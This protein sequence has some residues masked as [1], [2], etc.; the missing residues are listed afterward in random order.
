M[1]LSRKKQDEL[2]NLIEQEKEYVKYN[3]LSLFLNEED[4]VTY[5][6]TT[7]YGLSKYP[8]FKEFYE[9]GKNFRQRSIVA[10]NRVGKTL[11]ALSEIVCHATGN[12]PP[13]WPGRKY[14]RAVKIMLCGDRGETAK[15]IFQPLLLGD[16]GQGSG[17]I[18]KECLLETKPMP[19]IPGGISEYRIKS[20]FGISTINVLTYNAG[21]EAYEGFKAD[22]MYLDEESPRDILSECLLRTM[23]VKDSLIISTFTP[24]RGLSNTYLYFTDPNNRGTVFNTNVT[25][26]DVPHLTDADKKEILA[27]MSPDERECRSKGIPYLGKGKIYQVPE[28]EFV[29]EPCKIQPYWPRMFGMDVGG[30][31]P[32]AMVWGALDRDTDTIVLYGEHKLASALPA[33]HAQAILARG[34]WIPG[35]IDTSANRE[36]AISPTDSTRLI[37]IYQSFDIKLFTVKKGGGSVELGI[38]EVYDRLATGRLKVFKTLTN[39]L[40]EYRLYRRDDNS[41]VVK[42]NDD[43]MDATR[44]L[45]HTGFTV[46]KTE[47]EHNL[48]EQKNYNMDYGRSSISGY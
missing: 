11:R 24:D 25:W 18:P 19:G 45:I 12:Y 7:F 15:R 37:T 22:I 5:D 36:T 32:T 4:Y 2:L 42:E 3:K 28:S 48:G 40:D 41:K 30:A 35:V 29:I 14:N 20:K 16:E 13:T 6:G 17:L 34:K 44:Y 47:H 31:H 21:R 43:L 33:I 9:A 23:T 27:A 8:K 38:M 46:G 10:A 39:W 26:D 1:G